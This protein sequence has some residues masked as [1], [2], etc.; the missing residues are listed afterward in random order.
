MKTQQGRKWFLEIQKDSQLS[1]HWLPTWIQ[2]CSQSGLV[3]VTENRQPRFAVKKQ[4]DSL[5][6]KLLLLSIIWMSLL[7]QESLHNRRLCWLCTA[8]V[9]AAQPNLRRD[10]KRT[11]EVLQLPN[12]ADHLCRCRMPAS[13]LMSEALYFLG[14][15]QVSYQAG[16]LSRMKCSS[17]SA[18][19]MPGC[20][21]NAC[22]TGC[23][24][25]FTSPDRSIL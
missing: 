19:A 12:W 14:K 20:C 3:T 18:C 6:S 5:S 23:L 4:N 9:H 7:C 10:Q 8:A 11:S 13:M 15:A 17:I 21:C 1:M 2:R 25:M 24:N 16:C 22:T